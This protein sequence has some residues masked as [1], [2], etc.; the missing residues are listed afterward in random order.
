MIDVLKKVLYV[1][2][3]DFKR[4]CKYANEHFHDVYGRVYSDELYD[5]EKCDKLL[6]DDSYVCTVVTDYFPLKDDFVDGLRV[7]KSMCMID[8]LETECYMVFKK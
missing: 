3:D 8:E 5:K 1:N 7:E 6:K 2:L 4:V